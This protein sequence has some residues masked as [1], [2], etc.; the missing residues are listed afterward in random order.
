MK[1]ER[2]RVTLTEQ[3]LL[4]CH[5]GLETIAING[6]HGIRLL[7]RAHR[8]AETLDSQPFGLDISYTWR[9]GAT[10][11]LEH[12]DVRIN[13]ER[14]L[15][16]I[17][18]LADVS[19]ISGGGNCRLALTAEDGHGRDL[20]VS[21]MKELDLRVTV[22]VV[23]NV[24]GTWD[25]APGS[26]VMTG[27]HI[28]TVRTGGR[29]DGNYGV[30]AGLEVIQSLKESGVTPSRPLAVG[31]FT[32]EEGARF[33]PDM[34]GSLVYVGG[35]A[36][37]AALDTVAIDGARLADELEAIGYNGPHPCPGPPPHAFL[38]LHIEQGPVLESIGRRLGSVTGVQGISWQQVTINGQSNHAGTT[39]MSMRKDPAYVAGRIIVY[40]RDLAKRYGP[41]QVCTVGKVDLIPNL[42]NVVP[43]TA[44]LTVDIRNTDEATLQKAE[45]EFSDFLAELAKDEGVTVSSR[46]LARFEPVTFDDRVVTVI[47]DVSTSFGVEPHRLPSGAGHDAQMFAR[48]CPTAMI[49]VPSIDGISHNPAELTH[50]A[51]L[52]LG[53]DVLLHAMLRLAST[54]FEQKVV[55]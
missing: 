46:T 38:E 29:F 34:L 8:P 9:V 25:C 41:P 24:I 30:L 49:F 10:S 15:A 39:P 42:V 13:P 11:T 28:D 47:D 48:V 33:A 17:A 4:F 51:D 53:C 40:L 1:L 3:V 35:L 31:F 19:P 36:V 52:T 23:G 27:S 20:V 45:K 50:D 16:R 54:T 43:A 5:G 21:W 18:A 55:R 37:E 22:D 6:R 44:N 2:C 26:P 14:L 32:N 12:A 7:R